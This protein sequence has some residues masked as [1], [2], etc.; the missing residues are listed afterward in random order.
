LSFNAAAQF[1]KQQKAPDIRVGAIYD[2][3]RQSLADLKLAKLSQWSLH[4]SQNKPSSLKQTSKEAITISDKNSNQKAE[5]TI[6]SAS[7]PP[8]LDD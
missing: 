3:K 7:E 2:Q 4:H 1:L 8:K 6:S 5:P